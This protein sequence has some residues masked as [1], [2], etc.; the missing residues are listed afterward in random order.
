[1]VDSQRLTHLFHLLLSH[2]R[3]QRERDDSLTEIPGVREV[4]RTGSLAKGSEVGDEWIM[5]T[6]L[7]AGG[8][9]RLGAPPAGPRIGRN[10]SHQMRGKR[11]GMLEAVPLPLRS[12]ERVGVRCPPSIF[13]F[14]S[15][16]F[17]HLPPKRQNPPSLLKGREFRSEEHTS[18]LQS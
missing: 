3:I 6:R 7:D 8:L 11:R 14:P 16:I 13:H 2:R 5:Q 18:E 4:R 9:Q 12:G 15:S 17:Q 1:M 10:D